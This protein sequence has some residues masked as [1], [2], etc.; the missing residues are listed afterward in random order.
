[1]CTGLTAEEYAASSSSRPYTTWASSASPR[2][3]ISCSGLSGGPNPVAA[4]QL[5]RFVRARGYGDAADRVE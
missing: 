3:T 1:V 5:A 2:R 4:M